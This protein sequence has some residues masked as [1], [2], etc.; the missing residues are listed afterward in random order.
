MLF[1]RK[2]SSQAL[3]AFLARQRGAA[4]SYRELGCTGRAVPAGYKRDHERIEL[5]TGAAVFEAA[6]AG[7]RG[8]KMFDLGW[9]AVAN[10]DCPLVA[11]REVAVLARV[12]PVWMLNA[13][14]IVQVFDEPGRV[15][16]F[17]YGTLDEHAEQGEERFL[18]EMDSSR[19]VW[20]DLLA[21][22]RPGRWYV[23]IG[24][25]VARFFQWRF[26]RGAAAAMLRAAQAVPQ[27]TQGR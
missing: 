2:P 19:R 8:W 7:L 15:L 5:G 27:G 6:C 3:A 20:F 12:G 4:F 16:G 25:P 14:R 10:S 1:L 11:G 17:A 22:S 18:I 26:R 21:V 13:C 24:Y 9:T 23:R